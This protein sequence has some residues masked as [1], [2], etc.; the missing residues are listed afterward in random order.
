MDLKPQWVTG[1]FH[2]YKWSY[3][4]SYLELCWFVDLTLPPPQLCTDRDLEQVEMTSARW[5]P[6]P[7]NLG[8]VTGNCV[9][10]KLDPVGKW[11]DQWWSDQWIVITYL[12]MI[13]NIHI[14]IYIYIGDITRLTRV[15]LTSW[16]SKWLFTV[17]RGDEILP[18][19][20]G[21]M[22]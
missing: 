8:S 21:I 12:K 17:F 9:P 18:S 7:E 13:Y 22:S 10:K 20:V 3:D 14:Y 5:R 6:P 4:Y 11:M 2:P 19:D 16:T 1:F 15:L